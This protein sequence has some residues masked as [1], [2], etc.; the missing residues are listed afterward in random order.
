MSMTNGIPIYYSGIL[1][2]MGVTLN[3]TESVDEFL[4]EHL[5]PYYGFLHRKEAIKHFFTIEY[6]LLSDLKRKC[7]EPMGLAFASPSDVR[8]LQNFMTRSTWDHAGMLSK[9]QEEVLGIFS[10]EYS[11]LTGDGSDFPKQGKMSAGVARQHNGNQGKV[12][13]GQAG[14]MVGISGANG[15]GLLDATLYLPQKWFSKEGDYPER[16]AKCHIPE[17]LKFKTK[18]EILSERINKIVNSGKFK[19]RYIGVDSAFGRDHVFLDSLPG[20]L[21]YFANIPCSHQVFLCCPEMSLPDYSGRG[22]KPTKQVPSIKP[23][24][25]K[26]IALDKSIPWN[27]V[28][29]GNGSNGPIFA[30]DKCLRVVESRGGQPGKEVWLYLRQLEDES[31]KYALCNEPPEAS[32]NDVRRPTLMRWSIEQCF[33]ECKDFLGIDH[34]QLR[35]WHGW[36]RHMLLV[37]IAHLFVNKLRQRF[38]I[39]INTPAP[40]PVVSEPVSVADYLEAVEKSENDEV[41]THP[42]I[43]ACPLKPQQILTIGLIM[44][45]ISSTILKAVSLMVRLNTYLKSMSR[46]YKS[47]AKQ[48]VNKAKERAP[49]QSC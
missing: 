31:I 30:R 44:D 3:A 28:V 32:I 22:R 7:L 41:I 26:E 19:G 17:D 5:A 40:V 8:N 21:I 1:D 25:V 6:G 34:Y 18:N 35:S 27:D 48:K 4:L 15:Y 39:K 45:I 36:H 47:Q 24:S 14:V 12:D 16:W 49:C 23:V 29:L 46:A 10:D 20:N 11:M 42:S 2:A 38:A 43:S 33:K 13:N 9:Y 37:F